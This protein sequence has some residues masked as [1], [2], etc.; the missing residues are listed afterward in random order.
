MPLLY[1]PHRVAR[2][3]SA[4]VANTWSRREGGRWKLCFNDMSRP[5]CYRCAQIPFSR[6]SSIRTR[7]SVR[8]R[9]EYDKRVR[10][11]IVSHTD[12]AFSPLRRRNNNDGKRT[13]VAVKTPR[14]TYVH[15][16]HTGIRANVDPQEIS[17]LAYA[18]PHTID[19]LRTPP[20]VVGTEFDHLVGRR[21]WISSRSAERVELRRTNGR[22]VA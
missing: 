14:P 10:Y 2:G 7:K 17:L 21:F 22:I 15:S 8:H 11:N 1:W 3:L 13:T 4:G 16:G 19:T 20:L 12:F 5:A 6:F 9:I 18:L